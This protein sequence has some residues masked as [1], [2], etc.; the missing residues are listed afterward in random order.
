MIHISKILGREFYIIRDDLLTLSPQLSTIT[1][2]KVR[3]LQALYHQNPFPSTIIS[4]GGMQSNAMRSLA[5]LCK[6]KGA[7][8]IYITKSVPS[9]LKSNP[10]GNYYDAIHSGMQ[11]SVFRLLLAFL[12]N[13]VYVFFILFL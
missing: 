10:Q 4:Y 13:N 5:L 1:G 3:K 12:C 6:D 2:N 11:V 8:F 9:W 7:D